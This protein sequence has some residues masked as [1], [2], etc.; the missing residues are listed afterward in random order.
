MAVNTTLCCSLYSEL[1]CKQLW[2]V[3]CDFVQEDSNLHFKGHDLCRSVWPVQVTVVG[4]SCSCDVGELGW[5]CCRG[6]SLS[7]AKYWSHADPELKLKSSAK[8]NMAN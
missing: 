8:S 5:L 6:L 2:L 1:S 7:A 4:S 3:H